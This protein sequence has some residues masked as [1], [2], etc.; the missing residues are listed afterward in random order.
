MFEEFEPYKSE[1]DIVEQIRSLFDS[2]YEIVIS[3]QMT[4]CTT[5]SMIEFKSVLNDF[6]FDFQY[7]KELKEL[8]DKHSAEL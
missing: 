5:R 2:G 1:T 3:D 6:N 7:Q 8:G 4:T